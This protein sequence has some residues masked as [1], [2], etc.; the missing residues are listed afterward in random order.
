MLIELSKV[1]QRY[2]V[3][4]SNIRDGLTVPEAAQK[5]GVY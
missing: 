4:L 5:F 3:V 2:D 1:E